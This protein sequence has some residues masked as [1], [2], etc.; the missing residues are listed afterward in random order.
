MESEKKDARPTTRRERRK[1]V[2]EKLGFSYRTRFEGEEKKRSLHERFEDIF[3]LCEKEI[4][5]NK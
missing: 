2:E 4:A 5:A 3:A 1:A